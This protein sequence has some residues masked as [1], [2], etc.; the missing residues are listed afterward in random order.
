[1]SPQS[2]LGLAWPIEPRGSLALPSAAWAPLGTGTWAWWSPPR[3]SPYLQSPL[4]ALLTHLKMDPSH[5]TLMSL[6]SQEEPDPQT[7]GS[8]RMERWLVSG[9]EEGEEPLPMNLRAVLEDGE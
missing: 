5:S 2:D 7:Q 8:S 9:P 3:Y 4:P 1:M 6:V